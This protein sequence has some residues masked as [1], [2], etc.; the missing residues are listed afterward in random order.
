MEHI[1]FL[2]IKTIWD[3]LENKLIT[4]T[5][6]SDGISEKTE[7]IKN[8][9]KDLVE[10]EILTSEEASVVSVSKIISF[11]DSE[12]GRRACRSEKL[13]KEVEFNFMTEISGEN[14]II[15]GAIDCYF[16]E[17]GN[18]I[19]LDYKSDS[20]FDT[21][22]ESEIKELTDI[23]RPQLELYK[24]ALEKIRGIRVKEVYLYLFSLGKGIRIP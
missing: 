23:Y 12:I 6:I 13:Y 10:R 1:D 21:E 22:D 16:K 3:K 14:V 8:I 19:L 18:Y 24:T 15:Q 20:L 11:F 9:I 7:A 5:G 17:N 4:K 2:Q